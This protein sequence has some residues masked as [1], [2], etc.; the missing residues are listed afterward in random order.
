MTDRKDPKFL[1]ETRFEH[2]SNGEE[3]KNDPEKLKKLKERYPE[4]FKDA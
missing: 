4:F 1:Q 2:H 3:F